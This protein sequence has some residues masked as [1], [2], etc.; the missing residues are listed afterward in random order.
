MLFVLRY[1]NSQREQ[2]EGIPREVDTLL[3]GTRC[4]AAAGGDA[5][6]NVASN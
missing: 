5:Y 3:Q 4:V 2:F 1:V 6:L